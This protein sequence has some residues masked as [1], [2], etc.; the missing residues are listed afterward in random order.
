MLKKKKKPG[1]TFLGSKSHHRS[2]LELRKW[3]PSFLTSSFPSSCLS[4]LPFSFSFPLLFMY[5]LL[6]NVSLCDIGWPQS[7]EAASGSTAVVLVSSTTLGLDICVLQSLRV[8]QPGLTHTP[9]LFCSQSNP[10]V[11][12]MQSTFSACVHPPPLNM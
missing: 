8:I 7:P 2:C 3:C 1:A 11:N 9:S 12:S 10:H 6:A 4:P 5:L